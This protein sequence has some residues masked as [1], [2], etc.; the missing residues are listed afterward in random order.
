MAGMEERRV[1]PI[2]YA[3]V[4][5]AA[6]LLLYAAGYFWL[7]NPGTV[8]SLYGRVKVVQEARFFPNQTWATIYRPAA[9]LESLVRDEQVLSTYQ[10]QW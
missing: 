9:A 10:S 8:T 4:I 3:V 5:V 1:S 2:L 7:S 6:L